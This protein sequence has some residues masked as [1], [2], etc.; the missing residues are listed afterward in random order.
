MVASRF[1]SHCHRS[2]LSAEA[3]ALLAA[4]DTTAAGRARPRESAAARGWLALAADLPRNAID[5]FEQAVWQ[6]PTCGLAQL[7]LAYRQADVPDSARTAL[8]R[9]LDV[10]WLP[11]GV[12][13]DSYLLASVLVTLAEL[14]EEAG[15]TEAAARYYGRF[16]E[17][18]QGADPPLQR[19]VETAR[20]RLADIAGRQG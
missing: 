17:L 2:R 1:R 20:D 13:P 6:C 19:R 4:W 5:L 14:C 11:R 18:W 15:D 3:T 16:T 10:P 7:G 8:E 9:Y 12:G